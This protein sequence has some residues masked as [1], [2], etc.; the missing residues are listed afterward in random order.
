MNANTVLRW[1]PHP[2][3]AGII[4][5]IA[6]LLLPKLHWRCRPRLAGVFALIALALPPLLPPHCRQHPKLASAQPQCSRDTSAC[7]ASL[8]WSSSSPVA[9]LPYPV[10]FHG[11]FVFDGLTDAALASLPAL[12]FVTRAGIIASIASLLLPALRQHCC[13]RCAGVVTLVTPA[14]L[15]ASQSGICPVMTQMRHVAGEASLPCLLLLPVALSL[16]TALVHSNL[17]FNGLAEAAMAFSLASRWHPCLHHAGIIASIKLSLLPALRRHCPRVCL[18]R[19]GRCSAGI[20]WHCAGILA[21]IVLVSLPALRCH[22]CSR[23]CAGVVALF[24]LIAR[25][26]RWHLPFCCHRR[27]WRPC[28][29]QRRRRP[30]SV[31]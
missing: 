28:R 26:L 23:L 2:C 17:A 22:H 18:R 25:P 29:I 3:C 20:C 9:L 21:C 30:S 8:L 19:S 6:L 7:V 11:D 24:A 10:L 4:A 15:P 12:C 5:S 16:Y 14:L 1:R 31:F 27:T 13:P